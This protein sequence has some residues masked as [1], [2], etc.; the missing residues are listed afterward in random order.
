MD[1]ID[2]TTGVELDAKTFVGDTIGALSNSTTSNRLFL[3]TQRGVYMPRWVDGKNDTIFFCNDR[4]DVDRL[5][6][7]LYRSD[8]GYTFSESD[9]DPWTSICGERWLAEWKSRSTEDEPQDQKK[10]TQVECILQSFS[11]CL[12][13]RER[14]ARSLIIIPNDRLLSLRGSQFNNNGRRI[15]LKKIGR[16]H[17]NTVYAVVDRDDEPKDIGFLIVWNKRSSMPALHVVRD[18]N[19][20]IFSILIGDYTTHRFASYDK[21]AVHRSFSHYEGRIPITTFIK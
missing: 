21:E 19:T 9:P 18:V 3:N 4:V 17:G 2:L 5:R 8:Y 11:N 13:S 7:Y 20:Q 10:N 1:N 16:T 12:G 6:D 15:T 14:L